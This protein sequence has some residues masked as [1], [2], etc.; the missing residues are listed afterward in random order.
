MGFFVAGLDLGQARDYT[1]LGILD[2]TPAQLQRTVTEPHPGFPAYPRDR[3]VTFDG[4]PANLAL[5]H[6]ERYKLGTAYPAIVADVTETLRKVPG[7]ALLAIDATGVGAAVVDLFTAVGVPLIAVTLTG[8]TN[9]HGEGDHWNVPKRDV[10]HG[11]LVALQEERFRYSAQL[12]LANNLIKE[13]TSFELRVNLR[14]GHDS[15]EAW[16]E[17]AHDDLVLAV[18]IAAW[19]AEREV[20]A[21]ARAAENEIARAEFQDQVTARISPV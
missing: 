13:L 14:T 6:L 16:R 10:V 3:V 5:R 12:A 11:L 1:A 18:A 7:G 8:G 15:Y 2:V 4:P 9:V 20:E 19:V 17:G 21:A